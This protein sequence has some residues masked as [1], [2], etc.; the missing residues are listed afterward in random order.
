[1]PTIR[2]AT[3]SDNSQILEILNES[4]QF[5]TNIPIEN[6]WVAEV[7]KK[8]LGIIQLKEFDSYYL[9]SSLG[10]RL[11]SQNIGIGQELVK[12][13]EKLAKAKNKNI[14]IY[15]TIPD[16]FIKLGFKKEYIN[17]AMP[18]KDAYECFDCNPEDCFFMKK[19][20]K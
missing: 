3:A 20:I 13:A 12:A 17:N 9:L 14:L 18:P 6:F 2:Q 15:T 5:Y 19:E 1:M 4:D 7:D 11:K 10:V 8:I 16:F